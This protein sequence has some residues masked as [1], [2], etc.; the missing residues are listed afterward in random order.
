[1]GPLTKGETVMGFAVGPGG[2]TI[3]GPHVDS[4]TGSVF[5]ATRSVVFAGNRLVLALSK[6][7]RNSE[8][9]QF[10]ERIYELLSLD[11]QTGE[12][13]ETREIAAL[14]PVHLFATNDS[15]V[16]VVGRTVLRVTP[17]LNDSGAFDYHARGH[18]TGKIENIS[19]DGSTLGNAT[20]PGFE[21]VDAQTLQAKELTADPSDATS[22]N[23]HGFVTDNVHWIGDYPKDLSF[24]T[25]VDAIGKHLIYHGQCGGRPQFLTDDLVFEPGCKSPLI[26][27]TNGHV[28]RSLSVKGE[29]SYAGVSRNGKRLA[30]QVATYNGVHA[31]NH[32]HFIVYSVE[33]GE[34][35]AE[36]KPEKLAE[37]QSWTALSPDGSMIVVGSPLKL[38]LFRLP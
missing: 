21:L 7:R 14:R 11:T 31:L 19:P 38:S 25:Y 9:G 13:K 17:D 15:H 12:V 5:S 2:P 6:G 8:G 20:S 26:I 30:L 37:E 4:Q 34:P 24:I 10:P 23:D 27:D 16:I 22:V 3:T 28:I 1:V 35:I 32:E 29:F 18:K 33:T 36:V